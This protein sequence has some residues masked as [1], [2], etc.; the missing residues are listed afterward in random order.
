MWRC[1][2]IQHSCEVC[3]RGVWL[4]LGRELSQ[5][6]AASLQE[7]HEIQHLAMA[8]ARL[9]HLP[10]TPCQAVL[11]SKQPSGSKAHPDRVVASLQELSCLAY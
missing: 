4:V 5:R 2:C 1:Q 9:R 11:G 6:F 10:L 8:P 7:G 3:A